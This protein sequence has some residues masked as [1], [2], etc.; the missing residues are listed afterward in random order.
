MSP[1][2]TIRMINCFAANV[3]RERNGVGTVVGPHSQFSVELDR[4]GL[5]DKVLTRVWPP[6]SGDTFNDVGNVL[7]F[8]DQALQ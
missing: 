3:P 5:I 6:A 8:C 1:F 2:D 7:P 4:N